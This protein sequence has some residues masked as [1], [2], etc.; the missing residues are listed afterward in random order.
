M[1]TGLRVSIHNFC[2][3]NVVGYLLTQVPAH[4]ISLLY[5]VIRYKDIYV[6]N[7]HHWISVHQGL[8]DLH[9][10]TSV[11]DG[12]TIYIQGGEDLDE[13]VGDPVSNIVIMSGEKAKFLQHKEWVID[14]WALHLSQKERRY[15]GSMPQNRNKETENIY[16]PVYQPCPIHGLHQNCQP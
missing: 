9:I 14:N 5:G 2:V 11:E 6:F 7:L 15:R 12:V 10:T 13:Q 16:T 8:L 3:M 4:N 1:C